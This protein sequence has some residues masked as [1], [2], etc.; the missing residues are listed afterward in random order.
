ME[1]NIEPGSTAG[2]KPN[3]DED[4]LELA[5]EVLKS[6]DDEIIGLDDDAVVT[7]DED[8]DVID[9]TDVSDPP[10][11]DDDEILD[12][13]EELQQSDADEELTIAEDDEIMELEDITDVSADTEIAIL[14]LDE[15]IDAL[16]EPKEEVLAPIDDPTAT[17]DEVIDLRDTLEVDQEA[18]GM[19]PASAGPAF[20]IE[21]DTVELSESDREALENE[22]GFE[23]EDEGIPESITVEE[24]PADAGLLA[25][26]L[27]QDLDDTIDLS[28]TVSD[29]A[30]DAPDAPPPEFP[31]EPLELT[32]E[33]RAT[34]EEEV[35]ADT[36]EEIVAEEEGAA[37]PLPMEEDAADTLE[38]QLMATDTLEAEVNLEEPALAPEE[39][40]AG[41]PEQEAAGESELLLDAEELSMS[42]AAEEEPVDLGITADEEVIETPSGPPD[43]LQQTM[44]LADV[45]GEALQ[46]EI[47]REAVDPAEA[48]PTAD[49]EVAEEILDV[50]LDDD[51]PQMPEES[52]AAADDASLAVEGLGLGDEPSMDMTQP[53][54]SEPEVF[55]IESPPDAA[56][57]E[58]PLTAEALTDTAMDPGEEEGG[59]PD[60]P[61]GITFDPEEDEPAATEIAG[62]AAAGMSVDFDQG[63]SFEQTDLHKDADPIS[64]RV[65]EPAT[66][67]HADED[68]LLNK[69]F[70]SQAQP[71][72]SQDLE[73]T[74]ERVVGKM[75]AEK[76][77]VILAD[78]IEKAVEKEIGRLKQ[79]LLDDLNRLE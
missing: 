73:Q 62:A 27:D 74:V 51:Q 35:G 43:A 29:A 45:N 11:T 1:K 66:D 21:T 24:E 8:D 68:A 28:E 53:D 30:D 23:T 41:P 76:I 75:L 77:E 36:I 40:D 63:D 67:D 37:E 25:G 6:S 52:E 4:I 69:V 55:T 16:A 31:E 7:A 54:S 9:L 26:T 14:E 17:D 2:K 50:G 58:A 33:D 71:A 79:L 20:A 18:A 65:K 32:D 39:M 38:A 19:E 48:L 57:E 72:P 22:F 56:E 46:A 13:T 42:D 44:E 70:D 59:S 78:A 47:D 64:I 49:H 61:S 34:L 12:L 5:E 3:E 60:R 10:L 15:A